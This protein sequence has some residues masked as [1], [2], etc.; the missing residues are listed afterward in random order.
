MRGK[1]GGK[2]KGTYHNLNEDSNLECEGFGGA[3]RRRTVKEM[4]RREKCIL[5]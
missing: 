1:R 3:S 4:L 5:L 2:F